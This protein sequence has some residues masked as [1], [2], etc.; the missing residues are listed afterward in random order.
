MNEFFYHYGMRNLRD[1]VDLRQ[2]EKKIWAALAWLCEGGGIE[3]DDS[4]PGAW[5]WRKLSVHELK[6][7]AE[8]M[9]WMK[10]EAQRKRFDIALQRV[11][12]KMLKNSK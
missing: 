9:G 1:Y 5:E 4:T 12:K 6:V 10:T 7:K 11:F 2:T 8:S 3:E